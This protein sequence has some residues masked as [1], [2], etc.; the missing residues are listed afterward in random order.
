MADLRLP[1]HTHA[2]MHRYERLEE[3]KEHMLIIS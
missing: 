1:T 3:E 2:H